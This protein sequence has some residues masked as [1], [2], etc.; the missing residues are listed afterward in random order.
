MTK[1]EDIAQLPTPWQKSG[2]DV[3]VIDDGNAACEMH[4]IILADEEARDR[5]TRHFFARALREVA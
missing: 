1:K 2:Y 4:N 5:P 3:E